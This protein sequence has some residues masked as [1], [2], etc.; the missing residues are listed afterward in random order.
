MQLAVSPANGFLRIIPKNTVGAPEPG[1]VA[2]SLGT[3][4]D[5]QF[6]VHTNKNR[7]VLE[8]IE[9]FTVFSVCIFSKNIHIFYQRVLCFSCQ[10][11]LIV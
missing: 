10:I 7:R 5:K 4:V 8:T 11:T 2:I 3:A 9:E 1:T 6:I